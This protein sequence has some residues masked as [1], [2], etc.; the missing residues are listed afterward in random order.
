MNGLIFAWK[1]S[2]VR[3]GDKMLL[4]L[5]LGWMLYILYKAIE[6]ASWNTNIDKQYDIQKAYKDSVKIYTGE[7]TKKQWKQNYKNGKYSK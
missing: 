5:I 2:D 1:K 4:V 6:E 3:E 7:M